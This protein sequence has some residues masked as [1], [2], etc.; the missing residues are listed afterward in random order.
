MC[1]RPSHR[2]LSLPRTPVRHIAACRF[3]VPVGAC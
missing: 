3:P 2:P 1:R